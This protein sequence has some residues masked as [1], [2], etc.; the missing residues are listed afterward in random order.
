MRWNGCALAICLSIDAQMTPAIAQSTAAGD[1]VRTLVE[2]LDIESYKALIKGLTQFGDRAKGT[3]RNR[4]AVDWIEARLKSYGCTNTERLKYNDQPAP[5]AAPSPAA[6]G[7][8]P[9]GPA[10]DDQGPSSSNNCE[11]RSDETK[12]I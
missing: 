7:S 2:R 10:A 1:P 11:Q 12:W 6:S 9:V 4:A 8:Q 3:D 5:A